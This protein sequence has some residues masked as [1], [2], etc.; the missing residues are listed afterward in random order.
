MK[1]GLE[2]TSWES[3]PKKGGPVAPP[4]PPINFAPGGNIGHR[5]KKKKEKFSICGGTTAHHPLW[6]R[7]PKTKSLITSNDTP[8]YFLF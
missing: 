1:G 7:C 6:N 4:R 2:R 5:P 8:V 3:P